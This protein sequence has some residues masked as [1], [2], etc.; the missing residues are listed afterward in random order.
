MSDQVVCSEGVDWKSK[1]QVL[2]FFLVVVGWGG[3]NNVSSIIKYDDP[4]L[5]NQRRADMFNEVL[6]QV[7]VV[8]Q[9]K[10]YISN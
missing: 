2:F 6:A 4:K 5:T 3:N 8:S 7:C 1:V 9:N 10:K